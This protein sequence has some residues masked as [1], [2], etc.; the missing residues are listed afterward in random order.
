MKTTGITVRPI[1]TIDGGKEG[2]EGVFDDVLVPLENRVGAENKG[3]DYAKFL[4]GNERTAIARVGVSKER[5]SQLKEVG[6]LERLGDDA[7]AEADRVA[8]K[9]TAH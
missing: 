9:S 3:W 6:A 4:L 1:T 5:V 7:L 2:N 8:L